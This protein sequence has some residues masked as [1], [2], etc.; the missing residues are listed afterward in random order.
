MSNGATRFLWVQRAC[1][2]QQQNRS[3]LAAASTSSRRALLLSASTSVFATPTAG[4]QVLY[5]S[6]TS[7]MS[8]LLHLASDK[9]KMRL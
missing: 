7:F 5:C 4:S 8:L 6:I 1:R 9:P 2:C 3:V